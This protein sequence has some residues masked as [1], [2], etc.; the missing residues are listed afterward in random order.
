MGLRGSGV[1][2]EVSGRR[3]R[4]NDVFAASIPRTWKGVRS[5]VQLAR[6][7]CDQPNFHQRD[8]D[9][10]SRVVSGKFR[11]LSSR[12]ISYLK[13]PVFREMKVLRGG[14]I[15]GWKSSKQDVNQ[16]LSTTSGWGKGTTVCVEGG[17]TMRQ[18]H[19]E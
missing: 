7:V 11:G 12:M 13:K 19:R 15:M 6:S 16:W 4:G 14:V 18:A 8:L 5:E 10:T 2:S 3:L 17:G 1:H 9:T